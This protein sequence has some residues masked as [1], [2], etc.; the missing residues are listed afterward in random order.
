MKSCRTAF[1][2]F[3]VAVL[4]AATALAQNGNPCPGDKEYQFNIIGS[5][6]KNPPM[7]GTSGH[8]IFVLLNG[9]STIN[10][11]GDT[12]PNT[13]GLQCGNNF[14]I[15]DRNATDSDGATIVM[16]CD[17]LTITNLD[18][19]VCFD[20]YATALGTPGGRADVDV[21]CTFDAA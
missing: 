14:S 15:T 13:A 2:L 20:V 5:K 10:M 4:F 11:T 9:H 7:D 12:D 16:P 1:S 6:I 3:A 21:V 17:P 19:D 18:P 8:T